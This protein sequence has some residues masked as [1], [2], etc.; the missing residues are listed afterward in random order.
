MEQKSKTTWKLAPQYS[1]TMNP[2]PDIRLSSCPH[3][4]GKN[5]QRKLP[6]LIHIDPHQ[7]IVLNYTCRYCKACDLLMAHK[8]E[9][10]HLLTEVMQSRAPELIGN[11]YLILGTVSKTTWRAAMTEELTPKEMLDHT[12]RFET[13]YQELRVT[14]TGWFPA[15]VKPGLRKPPPSEEWVKREKS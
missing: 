6:L 12:R 11:E 7:L 13:V 3:C 9:I 14:Q 8:H 15:N 1:F 5:G 10:E 4:E 2:Y